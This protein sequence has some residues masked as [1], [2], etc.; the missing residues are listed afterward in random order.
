MDEPLH[1]LSVT[2]ILDRTA[3]MYRSRFLVF[4]GISTIP[5][6]TMFVFIAG[7]FGAFS[8]IGT[9][10]RHGNAPMMSARILVFAL[11][12]VAIP[13]N[14][15]ASALGEAAM[16]DSAARFFLGHAI[17][18][19]GAYKTAWQRGWR[20]IGLYV[21][22]GLAIAV[23]PLLV[24]GAVVA[25]MI[26]SKVSG[27]ATND[28]SPVF[29]GMLF[30]AAAVVGVFALVMLLRL[31]LAFAVSVVEQA[32]AWTALKRGT[33]LSAGTRWRILLIYVL[34]WFL[35][36]ILTW[37]LAFP[38]AIVLA[39]VPSLQGPAHAHLLGQIM[40]FVFYGAMFAVRALTKPVYGIA[41]TLFYFDSRIRKE[42]FDIEW[43]MQQAGL[44]YA[45]PAPETAPAPMVIA[46]AVEETAVA[47]PVETAVEAAAIADEGTLASAPVEENG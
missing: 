3:Q 25:M 43:M 24:F 15:A 8:W 47:V 21:L 16:T 19:R 30:L 34:G 27:Y 31:C 36:Q 41:L 29:G 32:G 46:S 7:I 35:N 38:L 9:V 2:E 44:V 12:I 6:M 13:A 20:Y 40:I 33:S 18:I 11:L 1:P 14:L 23:G 10:V 39:L 45:V 42:G 37:V 5:A 22:Q 4:L 17:T 28:P 26:I